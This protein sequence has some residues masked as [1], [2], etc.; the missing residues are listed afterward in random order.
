MCSASHLHLSCVLTRELEEGAFR[1]TALAQMSV[2]MLLRSDAAAHYKG[3]QVC[4]CPAHEW[5]AT[6]PTVFIDFFAIRCGVVF[7]LL[8]QTKGSG[9]QP[10][11]RH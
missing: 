6:A 2:C 10:I 4:C 8:G 11:T 5:K 9:C 3:T 7:E 1:Q